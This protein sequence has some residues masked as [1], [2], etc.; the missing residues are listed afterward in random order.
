MFKGGTTPCFLKGVSYIVNPLAKETRAVFIKHPRFVPNALFATHTQ[1]S[2]GG[3]I[4]S[5]WVI[6]SMV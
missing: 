2:L 1:S 6:K 4:G 5:Q 3:T